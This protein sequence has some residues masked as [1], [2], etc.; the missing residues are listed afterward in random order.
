MTL[1]N[2]DKGCQLGGCFGRLDRDDAK[3][4]CGVVPSTRFE[5]TAC[6]DEKE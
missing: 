6:P 2:K 1:Y 3:I 5:I 4:N